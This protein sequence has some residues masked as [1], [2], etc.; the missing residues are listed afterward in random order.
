MNSTGEW[1][2]PFVPSHNSHLSL[3][4]HRGRVAEY[5]EIAVASLGTIPPLLESRGHCLEESDYSRHDRV[6]QRPI[7]P[8][9][10]NDAALLRESS[11]RMVLCRPLEAP[12]DAPFGS[13]VVRMPAPNGSRNEVTGRCVL[14]KGDN[15]PFAK[16][17]G[18]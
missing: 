1:F 12:I 7:R 5:R 17:F 3:P 8:E 4:L 13:M 9:S 15:E 10:A 6:K 11:V 16:W 2:L 18:K 14:P